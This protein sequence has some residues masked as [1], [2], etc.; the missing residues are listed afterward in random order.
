M[1]YPGNEWHKY[2]TEPLATEETKANW[3][4]KGDLSNLSDG[5]LDFS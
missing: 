3:A 2:C 4:T 5:L 1:L